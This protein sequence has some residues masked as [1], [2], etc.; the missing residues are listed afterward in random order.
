MN[1]MH[2]GKAYCTRL[3]WKATVRSSGQNYGCGI[4]TCRDTL[5]FITLSLI[6]LA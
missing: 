6:P 1:P 4:I 2:G 5:E 3:R